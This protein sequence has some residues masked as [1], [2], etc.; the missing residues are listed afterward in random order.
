[1]LS[2]EILRKTLVPSPHR[3]TFGMYFAH[4][5]FDQS[6]HLHFCQRS[7]D[8]TRLLHINSL[9]WHVSNRRVTHCSH[10][11]SRCPHRMQANKNRYICCSRWQRPNVFQICENSECSWFCVHSMIHN[12]IAHFEFPTWPFQQILCWPNRKLGTKKKRSR[13]R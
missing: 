2:D 12:F 5:V 4:L 10:M 6:V 8:A 1:M 13:S 7:L 3:C 11:F 9:A